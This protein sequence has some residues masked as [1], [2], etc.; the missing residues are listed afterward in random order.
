VWLKHSQ[1]D[2]HEGVSKKAGVIA[3][4]DCVLD[5]SFCASWQRF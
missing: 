5:G 3:I 2:M 4:S 1:F